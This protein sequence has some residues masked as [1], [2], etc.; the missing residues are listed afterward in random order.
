MTEDQ[1]RFEEIIRQINELTEEAFNLLPDSVSERAKAYWY[2]HITT[3]LNDDN[4]FMGRSMCNM[5]DTLE[6]WQQ[7]SDE[8]FSYSR[9]YPCFNTQEEYDGYV[10][11]F[12]LP[13]EGPINDEDW[14]CEAGRP[15]S[16]RDEDRD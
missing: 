7:L 12:P 16:M 5:K 4:G 2:A 10:A 11:S 9:S 8:T 15:A 3:A 1:Q 14:D 13:N 6:D